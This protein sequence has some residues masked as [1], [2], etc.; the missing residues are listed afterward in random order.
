MIT[1]KERRKR[2]YQLAMP[3]VSEQVLNTSVGLMDVLLVGRLPAAAAAVLGYGS[4]TA[5]AATGLA[6]EMYWTTI[7]LFMAIGTGCT[8]LTARAKGAHDRE[9]GNEALRQGLL[10]G[11]IS[12]VVMTVVVLLAAPQ[13]MSVYRADETVTLLGAQVLTIMCY[14]LVPNAVAMIGMAALRGAGDTRTPLYIMIAVNVINVLLSYLLIGGSFGIAPLGVAGAAIGAA[15][16]RTIGAIATIVVL[17][18]GRAG[19][20]LNQW[21]RPVTDMMR[22][23]TR[24]GLPF[25]GEQAVF[26]G[27]L[28]VFL[29]MITQLG[30]AAY[31]AHNVAIRIESLSFLP[32][33][34]YGIAASALVGQALGAK[35]PEEAEAATTEAFKQTSVIMIVLGGI[36]VLFPAF[37]LRLFI[38]DEQVVQAGLVPRQ[39]AGVFQIGVGANFVYSGALR[40]AGDTKWPLYT[41]IIATWGLRLPISYLMLLWGF[42]LN[43]VWVAMGI[44]FFIQ[45]LLAYIRFRQGAWRTMQV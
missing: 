38:F 7:L 12:A 30:T 32:G 45:A 6:N 10:M 36:M 13:M 1:A 3:A 41:K 40:G 2:V 24:V 29:G 28:M 22:R 9:M 35:H 25:A 8:A 33:W 21:L 44:D 14:A 20:H 23:I 16:A 17:L 31:A 43:G 5:L 37:L 26:Q 19:L 42:G 15:V 34:G 11:I 4:A 39:I 18:R 27:A